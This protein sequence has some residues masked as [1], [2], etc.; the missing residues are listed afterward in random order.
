MRGE[1]ISGSGFIPYLGVRVLGGPKGERNS[2][3]LSLETEGGWRGEDV[4]EDAGAPT[5]ASLAEPACERWPSGFCSTGKKLH[6]FFNLMQFAQRPVGSPSATR[7]LIFL[8]RQWPANGQIKAQCLRRS[9]SSGLL[10]TTGNRCAMIAELVPPLV[11]RRQLA[12]VGERQ[13]VH[14]WC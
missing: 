8:R 9:R 11:G 5:L 3:S 10:L 12:R 2:S 4:V 7:H 13:I 1:S 6:S 14:V